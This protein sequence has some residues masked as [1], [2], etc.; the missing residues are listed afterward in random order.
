MLQAAECPPCFGAAG[1]GAAERHV[2]FWLLNSRLSAIQD[3]NA[4]ACNLC[5][6]AHT[7]TQ[8]QPAD[9]SRPVRGRKLPCKLN[10][11]QVVLEPG[12]QA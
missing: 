9:V 11:G 7:Q 1:C 3:L 10:S 4:R 8:Q 12:G 6:G 5:E 2:Q